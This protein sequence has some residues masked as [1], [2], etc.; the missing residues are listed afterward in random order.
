MRN[1]S[2]A[3][4]NLWHGHNTRRLRAPLFLCFSAIGLVNLALGWLIVWFAY[5]SLL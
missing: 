2:P 4:F 1:C 5:R 3:N